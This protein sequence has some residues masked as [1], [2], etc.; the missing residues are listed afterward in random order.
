MSSFSCC[1]S[2][3]GSGVGRL[4]HTGEFPLVLSSKGLK[5]EKDLP[6]LIHGG[7]GVEEQECE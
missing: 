3:R 4:L 1:R 2:G 6:G 5:L 7:D